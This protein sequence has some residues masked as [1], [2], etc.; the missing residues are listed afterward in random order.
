MGRFTKIEGVWLHTAEIDMLYNILVEI[1]NKPY[2][3]F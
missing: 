2:T 1:I 3:D